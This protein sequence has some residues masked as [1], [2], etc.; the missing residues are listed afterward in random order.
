MTCVSFM[1]KLHSIL[2]ATPGPLTKWPGREF[3][4]VSLYTGRTRKESPAGSSG[5][6]QSGKWSLKPMSLSFCCKLKP[7]VPFYVKVLHAC[8]ID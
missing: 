7:N 1:K 2:L 4:V 3:K 5:A 6:I 8:M